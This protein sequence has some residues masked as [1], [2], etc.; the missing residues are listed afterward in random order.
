MDTE[1]S[2]T[3]KLTLP[4]KI[5]LESVY[6][7]DYFTLPPQE[8]EPN[9]ESEKIKLSKSEEYHK[10]YCAKLST[11][12]SSSL[13]YLGSYSEVVIAFTNS[14]HRFNDPAVIKLIMDAL[15]I[16]I[17]KK[18]EELQ[19]S[20][21][22]EH[23]KK[24]I[25]PFDSPNG[26][27]N[28]DLPGDFDIGKRKIQENKDLFFSEVFFN[29]KH[30]L[31]Q[32][33]GLHNSFDPSEESVK[34]ANHKY[35]THA[36]KWDSYIRT[37]FLQKPA[38]NEGVKTRFW[39]DFLKKD[40]YYDTALELLEVWWKED[41]LGL[42]TKLINFCATFQVGCYDENLR[43][44]QNSKSE[45]LTY[46]AALTALSSMFFVCEELLCF[47]AHVLRKGPLD[48]VY[49]TPHL[50][51]KSEDKSVF[52]VLQ[53]I[54]KENAEDPVFKNFMKEKFD[55]DIDSENFYITFTTPNQ[56]P[57]PKHS[58]P[59]KSSPEQ[60]PSPQLATLEEIG[61]VTLETQQLLQEL[62]KK[63][64]TQ[65]RTQQLFEDLSKEFQTQQQL[66]EAKNKEIAELKQIKSP[67]TS[68]RLF[69]SVSQSTKSQNTKPK[70]LT[71]PLF[72]RHST[73]SSDA[74]LSPKNSTLP[75]DQKLS[76]ES[77]PLVVKN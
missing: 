55:K 14:L 10:S 45:K 46:P 27:I 21:I 17:L 1:K 37:K 43:Q 29:P 71:I 7:P 38:L 13:W 5:F 31:A 62:S 77:P 24:A 18:T 26:T 15:E 25:S 8:S 73:D 3:G 51:A 63:L 70:S 42:K 49:P 65:Q 2:T 22:E 11:V 35:H 64:E 32:K 39:D 50:G 57:S 53:Q 34:S 59:K 48:I 69:S 12:P 67:P 4:T 54:I 76:P 9:Q 41:R 52:I 23:F 36:E 44:R 6:I 30:P 75:S 16:F 61:R 20:K 47:L 74:R 19:K 66:I 40:V 72:T 58:P 33:L 68:S 60:A 28:P 56:K